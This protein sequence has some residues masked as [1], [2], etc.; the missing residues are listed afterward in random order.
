VQGLFRSGLCSFFARNRGNAYGFSDAR[1]LAPWFYNKRI[2]V[3]DILTHAV[4]RNIYLLNQALGWDAAYETPSFETGADAAI[5]IDG[6]LS[7]AHARIISVCVGSRWPSKNWPPAFFASVINRVLEGA[8][9]LSVVLVGSPD[10]EPIGAAIASQVQPENLINTI[11][12]TTLPGLVELLQRS[13]TLITNDSGPMHIAAM[14]GVPTVSF[15]GPTTP[16]RCG[17]YGD[18]H[19]VFYS[20]ASCRACYKRTC[21]LPEQVCY[22]DTFRANDVTDAVH[23][24]LSQD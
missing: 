15:F 8:T 4:D 18:R 16:E 1:E 5:E 2:A 19:K 12:K 24:L 21:P 3:P 7:T 6:L 11:G 13:R 10:D 22:S 20:E 23:E 14:L 17:P 9:E